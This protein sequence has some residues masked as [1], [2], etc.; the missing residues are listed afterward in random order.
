MLR[1]HLTI[2]GVHDEIV[3]I[4]GPEVN[5]VCAGRVGRHIEVAVVTD[6]E[7]LPAPVAPREVAI[8]DLATTVTVT[9]QRRDGIEGAQG[10]RV[11]GSVHVVVVLGIVVEDHAST[12]VVLLIVDPALGKVRTVGTRNQLIDG[13]KGGLDHRNVGGAVGIVR[14]EVLAHL[15]SVACSILIGIRSEWIRTSVTG[16]DKDAGVRLDPVKQSV[17]I[18]IGIERISPSGDLRTIIRTVLVGIRDK[19]VS[20]MG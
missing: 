5:V 13:D 11:P 7:V 20:R 17:A 3:G 8:G 4:I 19:R 6:G 15:E 16:T 2:R 1:S 14:V 10:S 12:V 18:R 9:G